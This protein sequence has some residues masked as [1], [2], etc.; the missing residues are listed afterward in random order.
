M[1]ETAD[2]PARLSRKPAPESVKTAGAKKALPEGP[3]DLNQADIADLQ[4]LPGIGA[5]LAQ[6]IV[7]E[8]DRR[9]FTKVDDLRRVSGIGVKRLEQ[10]KPYAKVAE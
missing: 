3:I 2:E 9:P 8:R 7:D 6:R 4:R 1:K 5:G 10:I